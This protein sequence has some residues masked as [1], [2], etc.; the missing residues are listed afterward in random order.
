MASAIQA[1]QTAPLRPLSEI[2]VES[3]ERIGNAYSVET[4]LL[5]VSA[6]D[7]IC[8][9]KTAIG[10][11][12]QNYKVLRKGYLAY[13]PMR[14]NIGSIGFIGKHDQT[15]ITSPDYVVFHCK[16]ELSPDYVYHFLRSEA[17]RHAINLKTKGSVRFRL[18]YEQLGGMEIPVPEDIS[19][20]EKFAD[21]CNRLEALRR[22]VSAVSLS[23][24][25]CLDLATRT[26]FLRE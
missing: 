8:E 6:E 23:V 1:V 11:K 18:Y 5:G 22:R 12:P 4:K 16:E 25:N 21:A 10:K 2:T 3:D 9:P 26:A 7:G 19:V 17:G 15:G 14:I 20:Q 13:N 24:Q